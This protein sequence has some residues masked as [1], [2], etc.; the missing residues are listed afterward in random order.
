MALSSI[1][2]LMRKSTG[3][4]GLSGPRRDLVTILGHEICGHCGLQYS[5][6]ALA[7]GVCGV[8]CI[9]FVYLVTTVS[10]MTCINDVY[11]L[12][13]CGRNEHHAV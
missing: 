8:A 5:L 7:I 10:C 4:G 6:T 13:Q 2:A 9:S 1:M 3:G 12:Y 11:L